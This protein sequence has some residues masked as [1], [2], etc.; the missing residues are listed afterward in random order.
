MCAHCKLKLYANAF[1]ARHLKWSLLFFFVLLFVHVFDAGKLYNCPA[2]GGQGKIALG[3]KKGL[4]YFILF[5]KKMWSAIENGAGCECV[6]LWMN[7]NCSTV[8]D[9]GPSLLFSKVKY[10]S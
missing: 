7:V 4:Q 10:F 1:K 6:K 2:Q 8:L 3:N 5:W 9:E